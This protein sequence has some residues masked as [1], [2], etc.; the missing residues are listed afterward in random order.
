M[1]LAAV[2]VFLAVLVF[3]VVLLLFFAVSVLV[4]PVFLAA[5]LVPPFGASSRDFCVTPVAL[6]I[7][8]SAAWVSSFSPRSALPMSDADRPSICLARAS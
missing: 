3:L 1:D 6:A 7:A 2:V 8:F 4:V 5:A